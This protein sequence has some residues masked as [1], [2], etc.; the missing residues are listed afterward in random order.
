MGQGGSQN[1]RNLSLFTPFHPNMSVNYN[2]AC[3]CA[4]PLDG[5][6]KPA[7]AKPASKQQPSQ[8][9]PGLVQDQEQGHQ[10]PGQGEG[11]DQVPKHLDQ[12]HKAGVQREEHGH[13]VYK[14]L[15]DCPTQGTVRDLSWSGQSQ[16]RKIIVNMDMRNKGVMKACLLP[17]KIKET[18][19]Q[20][21]ATIMYF[22]FTFELGRFGANDIQRVKYLQPCRDFFT[23]GG[24]GEA[25]EGWR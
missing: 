8:S 18:S 23:N 12:Q 9:L 17:Y 24:G 25:G 3:C 4:P 21:T 6:V 14:P 11:Q 15:Q 10:E 16:Q 20:R 5:A 1:R 13:Y 2:K 19:K 22:T 7:V